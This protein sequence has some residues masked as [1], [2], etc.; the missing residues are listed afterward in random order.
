[1]ESCSRDTQKEQSWSETKLLYKY[2]G[3][4]HWEE[5]VTLKYKIGTRK[6]GV[7]GCR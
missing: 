7:K 4:G 1:M 2:M 6:M 3:N 5:L